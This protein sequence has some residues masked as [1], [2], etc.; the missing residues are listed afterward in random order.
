MCQNNKVIIVKMLIEA[1]NIN[2]NQ[3]NIYG[4]TGFMHACY[5]NSLEVSRLLLKKYSDIIN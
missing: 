2:I 4:W 3:K 1:F 5:N